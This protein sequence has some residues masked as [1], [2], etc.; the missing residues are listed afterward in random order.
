MLN[1]Y[2]L[3]RSEYTRIGADR[4]EMNIIQKAG[5]TPVCSK[6]NRVSNEER[7]QIKEIV[8]E[9]KKCVLYKPSF[10]SKKKNGEP[11]IVIYYS[12]LNAQTQS[13]TYPLPNMNEHL[14]LLAES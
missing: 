4:Y 14:E 10:I 3:Y 7:S 9:W 5:S 12:K 6:P 2:R 11:R 8:S 1:E 13:V